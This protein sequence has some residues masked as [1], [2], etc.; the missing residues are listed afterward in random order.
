MGVISI[1][2]GF[3][4]FFVFTGAGA[5]LANAA[6]EAKA[7]LALSLSSLENVSNT[8]LMV[9]IVGVF[10][11]IGLLIGVNLIMQGLTYNKVSKIQTQL[12]RRG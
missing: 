12:R 2:L 11:F 3:I 6:V 8:S 10:T 7:V 4:A 9:G 5:V 1:L